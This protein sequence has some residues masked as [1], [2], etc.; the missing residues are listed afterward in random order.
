MPRVPNV[1]SFTM[2]DNPTIILFIVRRTLLNQASA[3]LIKSTAPSASYS[4]KC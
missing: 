4:V 1:E 2:K 3:A